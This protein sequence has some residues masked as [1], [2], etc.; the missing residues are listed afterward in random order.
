MRHLYI[1]AVSGTRYREG[2]GSPITYVNAGL[3]E[4]DYEAE[5]FAL[6]E[7]HCMGHVPVTATA[8]RV[9]DDAIK[10]AHHELMVEEEGLRWLDDD[11]DV[12]EEEQ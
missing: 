2:A 11:S 6:R 8:R 1:Y 12:D 9:S 4:A 7:F 3:F 5:A 10:D